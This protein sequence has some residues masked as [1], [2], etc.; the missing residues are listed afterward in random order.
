[1]ICPACENELQNITIENITLNVCTNGCGGTWFDRFELQKMDES[2]EFTDESLMD[3]NI[4]PQVAVDHTKKRNCPK[5]RTFIM[6]RHFFSPNQEVEVDECPKC[7]GFWLDEG[8]LFSL[9]NQYS[10]T[11][12]RSKAA[13][14]HFAALFDVDLARMKSES[15]EKTEKAQKI[16]RMFRL[17]SPSYYFPKLKG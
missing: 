13:Q 8:E 11:E 6:M 3:L 16:S 1:M 14:K 15:E 2:H 17:I 7:G 10:D 5:C 4:K 12:E 9:R